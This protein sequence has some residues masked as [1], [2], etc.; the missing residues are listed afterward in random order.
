MT[1]GV[2][3]A[4]VAF[5]GTLLGASAALA[6]QLLVARNARK[7]ALFDARRSAV[8]TLLSCIDAVLD[9]YTALDY[10]IRSQKT[11][12]KDTYSRVNSTWH[13][14]Q[15]ARAPVRLSAP[16]P[17]NEA[18]GVVK[19]ALVVWANAVDGREDDA[20][21]DR[22]YRLLIDAINSL[23]SEV[24]LHMSMRPSRTG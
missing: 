8:L 18:G 1:G 3:A 23:N 6:G 19:D 20:S 17:V 14:Y 4:L 24:E 10:A 7:A 9:A 22:K 12:S 15:L 5:I 16:E 11:V 21:R 2:V 13:E